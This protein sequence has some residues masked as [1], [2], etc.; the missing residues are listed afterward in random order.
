V[1]DVELVLVLGVAAHARDHLALLGVVEVR[2]ARVVELQVRAAEA[3]QRA[4]LRRVRAREVVPEAVHVR[5]D[6]LVDRGAP[7]AVVDHARRRDRELRGRRGHAFLEEREVRGEDRLLQRDRRV[8]VQRR[9]S[10]LD[11]ALGVVELDREVVL[12][13][14]D[15]AELIDEVHV[16]R[17]PAE[18][19]V[20]RRLEPHVLLHPHHVPDRVVLDR[21]QLFGGDPALGELVP[22]L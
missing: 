6:V 7:A 21:P 11:V 9:R 1:A 22:R 12:R 16:P 19:A 5:V 2:Q 4:D 14:R 17:G 15:A 10:E 13:A 3:G 18:L 20:G 8:D